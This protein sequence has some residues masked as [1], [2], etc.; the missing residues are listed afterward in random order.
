MKDIADK[1]KN[2]VDSQKGS[3]NSTIDVFENINKFLE[4]ISDNL[5]NAVGKIDDIEKEKE[6]TLSAVKYISEGLE[7]ITASTEE[8]TASIN[9]QVETAVELNTTSKELE[10]DVRSL[11]DAVEVFKV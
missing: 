1:A 11:Q 5:E 2:I 4:K 8:V 3:L 6:G 10:K 7:N 9:T